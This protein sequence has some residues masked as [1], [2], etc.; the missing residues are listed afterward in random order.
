MSA[1]PTQSPAAQSPSA[2]SPEDVAERVRATVAEHFEVPVD[3][4]TRDTSAEDVEGWDS[5]AHVEL[6]LGLEEDYGIE[7][8]P[9]ELTAMNDVGA[10]IDIIARKVGG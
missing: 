4:I 1:T 6:V 5:V 2:Q 7:F 8:E 3:T 10:L 9:A